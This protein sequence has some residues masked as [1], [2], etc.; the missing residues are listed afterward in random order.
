M[1]QLLTEEN[2][3]DGVYDR[4]ELLICTYSHSVIVVETPRL[5]EVKAFAC[6]KFGC[7]FTRAFK[8]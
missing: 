1:S 7:L 2:Y 3:S 6:V 5:V 4:I 8:F